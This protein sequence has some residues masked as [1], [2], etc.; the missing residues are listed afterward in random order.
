MTLVLEER[1]PASNKQ[2][3]SCVLPIRQL[4]K[5]STTSEMNRIQDQIVLN[6]M[7]AEPL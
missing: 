4:S 7:E 1:W 2:A 3:T 6:G 5:A